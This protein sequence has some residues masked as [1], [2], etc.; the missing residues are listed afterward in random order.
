MTK[1]IL[2][3]YMNADHFTKASL[4]QA[5]SAFKLHKLHMWNTVVIV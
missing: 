2:R 4:R 3:R 5:V 1:L